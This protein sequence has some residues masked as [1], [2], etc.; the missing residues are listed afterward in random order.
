[1]TTAYLDIVD[2][3]A[4]FDDKDRDSYYAKEATEEDARYFLKNIFKFFEI[5]FVRIKA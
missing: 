3:V 4:A 1:M 5:G 2:N